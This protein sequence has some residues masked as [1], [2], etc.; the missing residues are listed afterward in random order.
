MSKARKNWKNLIKQ[1]KNKKDLIEIKQII[2][3][4]KRIILFKKFKQLIQKHFKKKIMK[5]IKD[6]FK[7][8][9][10]KNIIRKHFSDNKNILK[11]EFTKLK[12]KIK[13]LK[14]RDS[15]FINCLN[16]I[17]IRKKLVYL[18]NVFLIKKLL[19]DIKIIK[20]KYAFLKLKRN[21]KLQ[22]KFDQL[23]ITLKKANKSVLNQNEQK[24]I[25][26]LIR[27]INYKKI[28]KLFNYYD[29]IIQKK[30][31]LQFERKFFNVLKKYMK[32]KI[33]DY[34][35]KDKKLLSN[36]P[37]IITLKFKSK[38]KDREKRRNNDKLS[39]I[40][41]V[42]PYFFKYLEKKKFLKRKETFNFLK[43]Y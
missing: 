17:E 6:Y 1:F 35:Y 38:S 26:K 20:A 23:G 3:C 18:N 22:K 13:H 7:K 39:K 16:K 43:F 8:T 28:N 42:I 5:K 40:K 29:K 4:L 32:K 25:K 14:E 19:H 33:V 11:K 27:I 15:K 31:K 36:K 41:K 12:N 24:F 9:I 21:L 30:L 37:K 2:T 34:E 10:L